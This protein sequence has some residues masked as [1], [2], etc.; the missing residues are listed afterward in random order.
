MQSAVFSCVIGG[1][2]IQLDHKYLQVMMEAG[3]VYLGMRRFKEARELFEGLAVM[4]PESDVPLV[5]IGNVDFC[6]DKVPKAIKRYRQALKLDPKSPFAKVY[7]GEALVFAGE[8]EE[9]ISILKEVKKSDGGA[10]E[11]A[12]A[13]LDAIKGGFAP[14]APKGGK[15][16]KR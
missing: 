13:L 9:G 10:A 3:Y 1:F 8:R 15:G 12:A 16:G 4:A 7:L 2:M 11:F 6:E 5:A 14:P